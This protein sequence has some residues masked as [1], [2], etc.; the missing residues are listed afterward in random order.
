MN[1]S[2]QKLRQL[3]DNQD[4]VALTKFLQETPELDLNH[5]SPGGVSALWYASFPPVDKQLSKEI[6]NALF[7][8]KRVDVTQMYFGKTLFQFHS[9]PLRYVIN[10]GGILPEN[11]WFPRAIL[12]EEQQ[13]ERPAVPIET[14]GDPDNHAE[15]RQFIRD[16]QS[17][18]HSLVVKAIDESVVRLYQ[19]YSEQIT[20]PVNF[21]GQFKELHAFLGTLV[22]ILPA[23]VFHNAQKAI[24]R[25]VKDQ[26]TKRDYHVSETQ[27]KALR[28]DEVLALAY[29]ALCDENPAH[30]VMGADMSASEILNRKVRLFRHL[31]QTEVEYGDSSACWMGTRNQIVATLDMTHIDVIIAQK[32]PL[33]PGILEMR[34]DVYSRDTL[35]N[36]EKTNPL[37]FQQYVFY[38]VFQHTPLGFQG[39]EEDIPK[40]MQDWET[41]KVA[42]FFDVLHQE[43]VG[44]P[45]DLQMPMDT[46]SAIR[47]ARNYLNRDAYPQI[48]E[49]R[50][51]ANWLSPDNIL[52][53]LC[54]SLEASFHQPGSLEEKLI[55]L[56]EV[57]KT[58][59]DYDVLHTFLTTKR[60]IYYK[61]TISVRKKDGTTAIKTIS[62]EREV[63]PQETLDAIEYFKQFFVFVTQTP[64][65]SISPS[66]THVTSSFYQQ[67]WLTI[68]QELL[69]EKLN[70]PSSALIHLIV[71]EVIF[72]K[73]PDLRA[74][75]SSLP[76][77]L[78]MRFI[79][80]LMENEVSLDDTHS[81]EL[82]WQT[83]LEFSLQEGYFEGL[84]INKKI[85]FRDKDFRGIDFQTVDLQ[86][87]TFE[88]C[89]LNLTGI[90]NNPSVNLLN[91]LQYN[92]LDVSLVVG[93][94][95]SAA[96]IHWLI[97]RLDKIPRA[98]S[99]LFKA[100]KQR[101]IAPEDIV[102][103]LEKLK[104][105]TPNLLKTKDIMFFSFRSQAAYDWLISHCVE[106]YAMDKQT[107][108]K[109]MIINVKYAHFHPED[110]I[111]L[112]DDEATL[113]LALE[114]FPHLEY[115]DQLDWKNIFY[116]LSEKWGRV[117]YCSKNNAFLV[118]L[119]TI[120]QEATG[121]KEPLLAF[122]TEGMFHRADLNFWE[123][124]SHCSSDFLIL[125]INE[126]IKKK[127]PD[128]SYS[129]DENFINCMF[130]FLPASQFKSFFSTLK[131]Y[132]IE[133]FFDA[134]VE[135]QKSWV[136]PLLLN[137]DKMGIILP[138]LIEEYSLEFVPHLVR[139]FKNIE[140][141]K[142]VLPNTD[143]KN[144][145]DKLTQIYEH[146]LNLGAG[147]EIEKSMLLIKFVKAQ[148]VYLNGNLIEPMPFQQF[149]PEEDRILNGRATMRRVVQFFYPIV[150]TKSQGLISSYKKEL[151]DSGCLSKKVNPG[152]IPSN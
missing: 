84:K 38:K 66:S 135:G 71:R 108:W 47:E 40:E 123:A 132:Q 35:K 107:L 2:Q 141:F 115:W 78:Q 21:Q 33:T 121:S 142:T 69:K 75:L 15:L 6:F 49:L 63:Y 120:Y 68:L 34:F 122:I 9:T 126:L 152:S 67:V 60:K 46:F 76:D 65:S 27:V 25:I 97:P 54:T 143:L 145:L 57:L 116:C 17:T 144:C 62:G 8:T 88:N 117:G 129:G 85:I 128:F 13:Y 139:C 45:P 30:F 149:S 14:Y 48:H 131:D 10:D 111:C 39:E 101:L 109:E 82:I 86:H 125:K 3:I 127:C 80:Q 87:V 43:N 136:Q 130:K 94:C 12:V 56:K 41:P 133:A 16:E 24:T 11:G 104:E 124:C 81:Q 36:L 83:A 79:T 98:Q 138:K 112:F 93:K 150:L 103:A 137:Q 53:S 74:W 31:A 114:N 64:Q 28:L 113:E 96:L 110:L 119:N 55:A 51:L 50:Y 7:D 59:I 95:S 44:L 72:S 90:E 70:S 37:L 102:L 105:T 99:V 77:H 5:I 91:V 73:Y 18:H 58:Q 147:G 118:S 146:A 29:L 89:N 148:L 22:N 61:D 151:T 42:L 134:M 92:T 32:Q 26:K 100:F 20:N 4:A 52:H 106:H 140:G 1:E 23:K 19:R